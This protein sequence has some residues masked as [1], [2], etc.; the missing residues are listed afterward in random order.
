[1]KKKPKCR[2]NSEQESVRSSL[3]VCVPIKVVSEMLGVCQRHIERLDASGRLPSPIKIGRAK[4]WL[5]SDINA[6]IAAGCPDRD[7]WQAM[8]EVSSDN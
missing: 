2:T 6:W 1:M 5:L 7:S 4:R 8:K 3:C